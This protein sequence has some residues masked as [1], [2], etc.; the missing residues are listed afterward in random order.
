MIVVYSLIH[1][2]FFFMFYIHICMHFCK[3]YIYCSSINISCYLIVQC[4][5]LNCMIFYI[6]LEVPTPWT[7]S[8]VDGP[9]V[10]VVI[11]RTIMVSHVQWTTTVLIVQWVVISANLSMFQSQSFVR[12]EQYI[13]WVHV[14]LTTVGRSEGLLLIDALRV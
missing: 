5:K 8:L 9:E 12:M 2:C 4:I 11:R 1:S 6:I 7:T 13:G 10:A 14:A 3:E